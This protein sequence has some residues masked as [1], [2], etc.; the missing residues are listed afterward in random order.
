MSAEV[1]P[2]HYD[3]YLKIDP[4]R[5]GFEGRVK[6]RAR[7]SR[8]VKVLRLNAARLE[9]RSCRVRA[10]GR[11]VPCEFRLV[12][13]EEL[14]EVALSEEVS[15]ELEVEVEFSGKY[16]VDMLGLYTSSWEKGRAAVTQFEECYAR[17]A[18][19]CFDHPSLK[20]RFDVTL[21]VPDYM[22]AISNMPPVSAEYLDGWKRVRFKTTPMMPTYLLFFAAGQF[23]TFPAEDRRVR[24][25]VLPGREK[26]VDFALK[27]AHK[28]L[29]FF[30]DYLK[31]PYPLPKL[32][33]IAV[34]DF[35]F[36]AM[37]NWGAMLFRENLLL[38]YPGRTT[39][40]GLKRV[41]LVIAH[42]TAHQWFGDL[43]SPAGWRYI[44]LN[45]SFATLLGYRALEAVH[46]D[47]NVPEM[48][49]EGA[50]AGALDRDALVHTVPIELEEESEKVFS[51]ATA[52][53]IYSKGACFL[54]M[55]EDY[56]GPGALA[57][58]FR[59]YLERHAYGA[60]SSDD[61]WRAVREAS[62]RDI[63]RFVQCWTRQRGYPLV[64][65]EPDGTIR[66]ER[67]TYLGEK[68]G[69]LWVLPLR[70]GE[71]A[72][73][74]WR[75]KTV[76]LDS[77]EAKLDV[78]W[79]A[80]VNFG[81]RSIA[82]VYYAGKLLGE[83]LELLEKGAVPAADRWGLQDD[84]FALVLAGRL[85]LNGYLDLVEK[86]LK[87]EKSLLVVSSVASNVGRLV[88][89]FAGTPIA[90][91]AEKALGAFLE[92]VLS[93]IGWEPREGEP[94]DYGIARGIALSRLASLGHKDALSRC[95]DTFDKVLRGQEVDPDLRQAAFAAAAHQLMYDELLGIYRTTDSEAER[96]S[97]LRALSTMPDPDKLRQ[98]LQYVLEKVPLR[99]R[100]IPLALALLNK[101][102]VRTAWDWLTSN[103]DALLK[104]PTPHLENVID[105]VTPFACIGREEDAKKLLTTHDKLKTLLAVPSTLEKLEV[106]SRLYNRYT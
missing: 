57:E 38:H 21:E 36:G 95:L 7:A 37:E 105:V 87:K 77:R 51:P 27:H 94:I 55:L 2:E 91:R 96:V 92:S 52:P 4:S 17:R 63:S 93:E 102:L 72:G 16:S 41:G 24:I 40:D 85:D 99:I 56:V 42:E 3:V 76:V 15:G 62:G 10:G 9:V 26:Y 20:A 97:V 86:R 19:P 25:V 61:F 83:V 46:P 8:P 28:Y 60:A 34:P 71:H 67:F 59:R 101:H 43:V 18:F 106:Y 82:R 66:Q 90:D 22:E 35:A 13:K 98:F 47:W 11:E 100:F 1:Q 14:L 69:E 104:L 103:L 48:F 44:W 89:V 84:Y 81:R 53:I 65:V 33:L 75:V 12:P 39:R 58:A 79:P 49:V 74:E 50:M 31:V 73:T 54:Q 78:E 45:E 32:D 5:E 68:S 80:L 30:E 23:V 6:V 70:V 29:K 64:T 88:R